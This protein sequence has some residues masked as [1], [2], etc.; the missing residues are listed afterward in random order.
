VTDPGRYARELAGR[1]HGP[2]DDQATA[3]A[4]G[5]AA[6]TIRYLSYA[7][8]HGGFTDPATVDAVV[9]DLSTA[10]GRLP[11]LLIQLAGWIAAGADA[12]RIYVITLNRPPWPT[13]QAHSPVH[14]DGNR[15]PV[16]R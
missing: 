15:Q 14:R 16:M 6:E 11:Q 9:G 10:A 5:L 4:A 7:A 13:R 3:G 12:G 2:H 8:A 1:V